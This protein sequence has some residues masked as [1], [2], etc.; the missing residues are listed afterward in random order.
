[1]FKVNNSSC[2]NNY[3]YERLKKLRTV[4]KVIHFCSFVHI[5]YSLIKL[6]KSEELAAIP[7]G[8]DEKCQMAARAAL[9][10]AHIHGD[11]LREGWQNILN[12]ILPL[13]RAKLLPQQLMEAEDFVNEKVNLLSEEVVPQRLS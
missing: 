7:F 3:F 11:I 9:S 13:F 5:R 1:M 10:L 8:R 2:D 4:P 12:I 6:S